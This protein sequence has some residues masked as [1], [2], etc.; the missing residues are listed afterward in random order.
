MD[1]VHGTTVDEGK[2]MAK[3]MADGEG[4]PCVAHQASTALGWMYTNVPKAGDILKKVKGIVSHFK[5]SN[6]AWNKLQGLAEQ[7]GLPL[8]KPHKGGETRCGTCL[9][10]PLLRKCR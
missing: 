8:R 2:N 10:L 5:R 4:A 1:E 6:I 7:K 3:A 9:G